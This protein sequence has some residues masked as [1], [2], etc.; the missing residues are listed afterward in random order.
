M[1]RI[2]PIILFIC[3]GFTLKAQEENTRE[4]DSLRHE[5]GVVMTVI[6]KQAIQKSTTTASGVVA[7]KIKWLCKAVLNF[8]KS[9]RIFF[10]GCL[11]RTIWTCGF[12]IDK[13]HG[14]HSAADMHIAHFAFAGN[15]IFIEDFV[16]YFT[17]VCRAQT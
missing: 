15:I 13:A 3:A 8:F 11:E 14:K 16:Y 7:A 5:F 10:T 9:H 4:A 17:A 12:M 1:K 2:L 6:A